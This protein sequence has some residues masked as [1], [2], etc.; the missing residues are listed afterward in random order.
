VEPAVAGA[1]RE[2][3][4]ALC[5]Y[6]ERCKDTL[7][8]RYTDVAACKHAVEQ[9]LL[10]NRRSYEALAR[11]YDVDAAALAACSTAL[12]QSACADRLP[13]ALLACQ[14][15]LAPRIA[16]APGGT[17]STRDET[18]LPHCSKNSQNWCNADGTGCGV[19]TAR[20]DNGENCSADG[21]C[22]TGFCNTLGSRCADLPS[23]K[24]VGEG[25]LFTL[26][27]KGNLVCAGP[28]L[29]K[30]CSK[31]VGGGAECDNADNGNKPKCAADL[32]CVA[33]AGTSTCAL[34]LSSGQTC[35]RENF[36]VGCADFCV[37]P[38]SD[39]TTGTCGVLATLPGDGQPCALRNVGGANV[40][41]CAS[42]LDLDLF[43][44]ETVAGTPSQVVSCVCRARQAA[45]A[46]C[47]EADA[48]TSLVCDGAAGATPGTCGALAANAATCGNN[49][50]CQS[51]YCGGTGP[52]TCQPVPACQ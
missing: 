9:E 24:G 30:T 37:F 52:R 20:K 46:A 38:S 48:C 12:A 34:P 32:A 26:E 23:G 1:Y 11:G 45:G 7:G 49:R 28:A 43:T 13:P 8:L 10:T 41:T 14:D 2:F 31:R 33:G 4:G 27:C 16:H 40:A 5:A 18:G 42:G 29:Q 44:L 50:D 35:A 3:Y 39:A 47:Q 15:A 22:K 25:C 19:C 21:Q 6:D 51:G 17:C 36:G